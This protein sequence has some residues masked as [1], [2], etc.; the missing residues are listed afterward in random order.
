MN[1][2]GKIYFVGI[3][4]GDPELMTIKAHKVM[5][6]ADIIIY[7]G[8]LINRKILDMF[9]KAEKIDSHG[10]SVDE[11][12][13][14]MKKKYNDGKVVARV[15]DGDPC[16]FGSTK[17]YFELLE[18]E[19][20]D[21]EIIPGVSSFIAAA[22][23]LKMEYTIPEITQSIVITRYPGKTPVPEDIREFMKQKPT[24]IFFLSA[25]LIDKIVQDLLSAGFPPEFPCAVCYKVSWEDQK[26][27]QG[28]ISDISSKIKE[29]GINSH[30][31]F[32]V[33]K[34]FQAYG[35][36][37]FVYSQQYAQMVRRVKNKNNHSDESN[38][39]IDDQ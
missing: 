14:I 23:A 10:L 13:D 17:E 30:A 20:I 32:I 8:S 4:P 22:S 38:N 28:T 11:I 24:I 6:S 39:L 2:K 31:L 12:V 16:I 15:H 3:G 21:F 34:A 27:I 7:T 33:S 18:K 19:G 25:A 29:Q 9:P 26:I 1:Q 5:S 36:R 35:N 37:S